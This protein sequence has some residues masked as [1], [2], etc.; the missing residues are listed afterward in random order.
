MKAALD[1]LLKKAPVLSGMKFVHWY[2][3]PVEA[4]CDCIDSLISSAFNDEDDEDADLRQEPDVDPKLARDQANEHIASVKTG[5]PVHD[6][7]NLYYILLLS[8]VAAV[9]WCVPMKWA[10]MGN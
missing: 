1:E 8:G 2:D 4:E 9:S 3:K 6:L 7:P 5:T 10:I